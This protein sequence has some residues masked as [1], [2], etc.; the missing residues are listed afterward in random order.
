MTEDRLAKEIHSTTEALGRPGGGGFDP[1]SLVSADE[2]AALAA[3]RATRPEY[4][5]NAL[6]ARPRRQRLSDNPRGRLVILAADHPGRMMTALGADPVGLANRADYLARIVRVL[7]ASPVDGLMA[8]PDVIE[9]VVVL[10]ALRRKE[11]QAGFLGR[12]LLIGSMNRSGLAGAA[13][14]LWDMPSAY[15]HAGDLVAANLDGGKILWRYTAEGEA[16]REAL[17]TMAAL[18]E[19]VGELAAVDLPV[20]IEALAVELKDGRWAVSRSQAEWLRL[21][22]AASSL[23]PTTARS[24]LKIPFLRPYER[25]AAATTLPILMLGG[26]ATGNPAALLVDF[27]EGLRSGRNVYGA[28]VGRNILYPGSHDPAAMARAVCHLVHDGAAAE[29]AARRAAQPA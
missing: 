27:A 3:V 29:E 18:A 19:L 8:T 24:W 11:G 4:V 13:H 6:A 22:G 23:G 1:S 2:L 26:P 10:D 14:E 16:N 5:R 15:L 25:I 9:D 28:L 7:A 20:F 21:V 12:R 17:E